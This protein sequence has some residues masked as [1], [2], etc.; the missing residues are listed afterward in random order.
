MSWDWLIQS[1]LGLLIVALAYAWKRNDVRIDRLEREQAER[2]VRKD[3]YHRDQDTFRAD[4]C[5]DKD[6]TRDVLVRMETK[7][8]KLL[9]S[10]GG[11]KQ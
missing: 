2:Y 1:A 8:D 10:G 9:A 3:D 5:R 7:I 6:D 11:A 4:Y